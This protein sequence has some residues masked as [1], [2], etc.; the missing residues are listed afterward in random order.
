MD[1]KEERTLTQRK[2][3]EVKQ[4][5]I[6]VLVKIQTEEDIKYLVEVANKLA[7]LDFKLI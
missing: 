4:M 6:N 2:F 5:E 7:N 1:T 3:R